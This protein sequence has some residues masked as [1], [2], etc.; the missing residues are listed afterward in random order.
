[1]CIPD[2]VLVVIV[3]LRPPLVD[4]ANDCEAF[5]APLSEVSPPPAPASL[6]QLNVPSVQINF[7]VDELQLDSDAP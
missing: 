6:A 7:C 4:V 2:P 1:M 3:R 5:V